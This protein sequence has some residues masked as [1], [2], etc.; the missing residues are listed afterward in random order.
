MKLLLGM[1]GHIYKND[2]KQNFC[3]VAIVSGVTREWPT[4]ER[5]IEG[6]GRYFL[7]AAHCAVCTVQYNA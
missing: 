1:F 6:G 2:V 5:Y 3:Y 7:L 4:F